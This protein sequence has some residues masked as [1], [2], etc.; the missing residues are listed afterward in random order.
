MVKRVNLPN[1]K[2]GK[3]PDEMQW[4]EI[5]SIVNSQF[6]QEPSGA[7]AE[8]QPSNEELF[9]EN[10]RPGRYAEVFND[11]MANGRVM[12]PITQAAG[13]IPRAVAGAGQ[14]LLNTA[15]GV[16]NLYSRPANAIGRAITGHDITPNAEMLDLLPHEPA[17]QVG[18]A[19]APMG[20]VSNI[21]KIPR[22]EYVANF[23]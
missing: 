20:I 23:L 15:I 22:L 3:F 8:K 5:E 21:G 16:G 17:E 12:G 18:E 14:G 4:P 13:I 19:F 11:I 7:S 10:M 9:A 6:P 1:G 2:V